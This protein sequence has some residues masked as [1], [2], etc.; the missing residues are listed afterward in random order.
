MY[1]EQTSSR[2]CL[3]NASDRYFAIRKGTVVEEA[4][5]AHPVTIVSEP[6]SQSKGPFKELPEHLNS[7]FQKSVTDLD[8]SQRTLL[9]DL[10]EEYQD[11]S[12]QNEFDLGSFTKI[13]HSIDTGS[14]PPNK[15]R[16]RR[17]PLDF[18]QEEKNHLHTMLEAGIVEPSNSEWVSTPVLVRKKRW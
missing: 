3:V 6:K 2:L 17:R 7:L 9:M 12:D 10:L 4:L 18:V 11:V 15:Q 5:S 14:V 1:S 8:Q 13:E 16:M